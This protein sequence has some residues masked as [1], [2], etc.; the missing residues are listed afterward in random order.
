MDN[1]QDLAAIAEREALT[2][3]WH[4]GRFNRRVAEIPRTH[5]AGPVDPNV[6]SLAFGAPSPD[7]FPAAGLAEAARAGLADPA[8]AAVGL[9]YGQVYGNPVLAAELLKK[10]EHDEAR[11]IPP[12]WL[13]ITSGSG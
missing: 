5:R 12:D 8:V 1:R 6:I 4:S 9:Q 7:L 13:I 10:L 3:D 11:T 2:F